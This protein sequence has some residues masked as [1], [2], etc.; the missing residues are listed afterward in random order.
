MNL[1]NFLEGI[2]IC[3]NATSFKVMNKNYNQIS[4]VPMG[5][6][7][8]AML[9]NLILEELE[10]TIVSKNKCI[11]LYKRYV[12]DIIIA[13]Q[14]ENI[15]DIHNIFNGYNN[16]I[17]FTIERA[18]DNKINFLDMTLIKNKNKIETKWFT[19]NV[20]S[21]RYLNFNS[22]C[23]LS[24]KVGLIKCIL[25]RAIVLTTPKYRQE[26]I[27]K[28]KNAL[29]K[30]NYPEN[31]INKHIKTRTYKLYNSCRCTKQNN[32]NK[33]NYISM[34]YVEK[35][36]NMLRNK[37][38]KYNCNLITKNEN[39][40]KR[41]LY[42]RIKEKNEYINNVVYRVNCNNC[43]KCY[44]GQTKNYLYKRIDTHK[45]TCNKELKSGST[46]LAYHAINEKHKF[47]FDNIEILKR[48][49]N[50]NKR[51]IYECISV[52][53]EKNSC[54]YRT[55]TKNFSVIYDRIL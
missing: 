54:N 13:A 32:E 36:Y 17:R 1:N 25:D 45:N 28:V 23:D 48:E 12:D 19:K 11:S 29:V 22:K 30:N 53:R 52:R 5:A 51:L 47:D 40:I 20:W 31:L 9:A 35:L 10:K 33:T 42:S 14:P 24:Y 34:P 39:T 27:N 38:K 46:A 18:I 43:E 2:K 7:L 21:E 16:D 4:G 6:P 41:M 49:E 37:F 3:I 55:D 50:L 26:C 8:S 44:I 15:N